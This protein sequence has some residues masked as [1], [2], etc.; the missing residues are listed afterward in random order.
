MATENATLAGGCFW[1]IEAV[2]KD[3]KGVERV[4]PGYTG[5]QM[6]NPTYED[7][8]T[9]NTGHAEALH[10]AFDPDLISYGDLLDV[11]FT[12]HDPTQLNRQGGDLGTQYRSAIF[13]HSEEQRAE[14][15]AAIARARKIWDGEIVT[16]ITPAGEFWPA[17]AYH[18]DYFETNP[19][20]P[21]CSAVI[22]PKVSKA[23]QQWA[24]KLKKGTA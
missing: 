3:L 14:A 2:F 8:C 9:G 7:V 11:F 19:D 16:E 22:A 4:L 13:Y 1:C 10:I 5:G 24:A 15:E 21:Y 12:V 6:K 17:E 23:R 20:T 18:R